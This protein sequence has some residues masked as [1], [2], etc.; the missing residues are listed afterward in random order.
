MSTAEEE[1]A[2]EPVRIRGVDFLRRAE[3]E[4]RR[5]P[6]PD[7]DRIIAR[8]EAFAENPGAPHHDVKLL[9]NSQSRRLRVGDYRVVLR[10]ASGGRF[11]VER[12]AHGRE[13]Y[14]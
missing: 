3:K 1:A 6:L 9:V 12:V 4:L 7:R 10:P 14:R 5:I 13:V 2:G 8:I 11:T